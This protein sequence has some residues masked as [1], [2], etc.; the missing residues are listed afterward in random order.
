MLG[1]PTA[2]CVILR[3][4]EG[5]LLA[6]SRKDDPEA[7]GLPGGSI[8]PGETPE[9]AIV[10]ETR[11]ETGLEISNLQEVYRGQCGENISVGFVA[12]YKGEPFQAEEGIV[13]WVGP[14]ALLEGPFGAYN[15]ELFLSLNI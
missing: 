14:D 3:N 5:R 10:R 1:D 15:M 12:D 6:V 13:K 2:V 7:M 8:E 4:Q 9:E 11:E